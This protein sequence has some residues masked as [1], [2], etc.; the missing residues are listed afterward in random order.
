MILALVSSGRSDAATSAETKR[1]DPASL[2]PETAS[3]LSDPPSLAAF[4]KAVPRTVMTSLVS[5]VFTC[6]MALPA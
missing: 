1:A 6:A 4:S 5:L 3:T 2:A